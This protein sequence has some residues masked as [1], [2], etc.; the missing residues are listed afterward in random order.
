VELRVS[1]TTFLAGIGCLLLSGAAVASEFG[2]GVTQVRFSGPAGMKVRVQAA[3]GGFVRSPEITAPG[4]LNLRQG[5]TYRLRLSNFPGRPGAVF[6]PTLS[7]IGDARAADFLC[8]N[9]ISLGLTGEDLDEAAAGRLV[10]RAVTL[11]GGPVLGVLRMGDIDL[12]T[13]PDDR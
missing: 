8:H 7:V 11:P 13:G 5:R 1:R 10:T 9:T 3:D 6:Y 2:V 12:G 4:R